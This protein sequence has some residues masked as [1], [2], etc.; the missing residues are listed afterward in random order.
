MAH[1]FHRLPGQCLLNLTVLGCPEGRFGL[2]FGGQTE[3]SKIL[4]QATQNVTITTPKWPPGDAFG[5][6]FRVYG[7]CLGGL[8]QSLHVTLAAAG[9]ISDDFLRKVRFGEFDAYLT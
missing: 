9:T 5:S 4:A 7:A 6:T 3:F 8:G 2:K 1:L